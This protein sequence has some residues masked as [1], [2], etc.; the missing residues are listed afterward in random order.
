MYSLDC[1]DYIQKQLLLI[2]YKYII[3]FNLAIFVL[4]NVTIRKI[5][6]Y[7]SE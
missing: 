4:L 1:V 3:G 6:N 2:F 5:F 7:I